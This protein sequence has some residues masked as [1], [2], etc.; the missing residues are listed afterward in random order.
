[1]LGS[2]LPESRTLLPEGRPADRAPERMRILVDMGH[3]AHVHFFKNAIR[4]LRAEGHEVL[5]SAR[6]KDVTTA[7]LDL[8]GFEYRRLSVVSEGWIGMA[9]EFVKRELALIRLIRHYRPHVLT[10]VGGIFIAPAGRLTRTPTVVFTDTEHVSLDRRLTYPWATRICT[11]RAFKTDLG[12]RQHRY[13]GFQ[14]LAY[15]HPRY[16]QPDPEILEDLGLS[17]G[18]RFAVMRLVSWQATHDRGQMG[19]PDELKEEALTRLRRHGPVLISSEA[20]LPRALD[21]HAL[22]VEPHRLHDVLALASLYLGEGATMATEAG[23]LGTPSVYVSSLVGTMGN[24]EALESEGLVLSFRDGGAALDRAEA[25]LADANAKSVWTDRS[26]AL[27][28]RLADVTDVVCHQVL[29]AGL[30][31]AAGG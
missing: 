8:L 19:L 11:P 22:R 9:A 31:G 14:E 7:L 4:R 16:F 27:I 26:R 18:E 5:I 15:L 12:S 17:A 10:A 20:P 21:Q 2:L 25:L 24:F 23:L 30:S 1:M 29:E 13:A 28:S 6:S 3:P